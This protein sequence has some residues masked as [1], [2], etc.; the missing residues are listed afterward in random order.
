MAGLQPCNLYQYCASKNLSLFDLRLPCVFCK[1]ELDFM[2]LADF[3]LKNLQLLHK[4]NTCYACCSVCLRVSAKFELENYFQC[5]V[6]A[7]YFTTLCEK[8]LQCI[9]VRCI[10]CYRLLD[11][12]EKVDCCAADLPF[13]LVRGRWRNFCRHCIKKL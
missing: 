10:D 13:C 9:I 3:H 11:C 1:N 6:K 4:E 8:P 2:S 7:K 12:M 5:Y